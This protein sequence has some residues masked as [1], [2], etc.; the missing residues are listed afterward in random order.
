MNKRLYKRVIFCIHT[1]ICEA[2]H[3][4]TENGLLEWFCH[5]QQNSIVVGGQ[6]MKIKAD[7]MALILKASELDGSSGSK[8]DRTIHRNQ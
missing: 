6:M 1:R 5:A 4:T 8:T 3:G 2:K 7:E